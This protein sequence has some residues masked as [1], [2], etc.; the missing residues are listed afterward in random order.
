M[1]V[2]GSGG[3]FVEQVYNLAPAV[4]WELAPL[5]LLL[6]KPCRAGRPRRP[7]RREQ[8]RPSGPPSPWGPRL[9]P[10]GHWL[11]EFFE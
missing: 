2:K 1:Q 11:T 5:V 10:I 3:S 4:A 9:P 7:R 6:M 8:A